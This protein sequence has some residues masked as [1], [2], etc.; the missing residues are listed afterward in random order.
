MRQLYIF[1]TDPA[2]GFCEPLTLGDLASR[3]AGDATDK[4]MDALMD[5][6]YATLIVAFFAATAGLV[7]FCASLLGDKGQS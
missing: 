7:R 3:V 5:L 1:F 4:A 2:P 6:A